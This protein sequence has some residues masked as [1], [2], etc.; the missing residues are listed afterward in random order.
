M[1]SFVTLHGQQHI[2]GYSAAVPPATSPILRLSFPSLPELAAAYLPPEIA[3]EPLGSFQQRSTH[4]QNIISE[5]TKIF[6]ISPSND[7][8]AG[9]TRGKEGSN[10]LGRR[11][12][13]KKIVIVGDS[14][15]L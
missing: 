4:E 11:K 10:F 15:L 14:L 7:W 5:S 2:A 6:D 9:E 1:S 13:E 3:A 8:T 12:S